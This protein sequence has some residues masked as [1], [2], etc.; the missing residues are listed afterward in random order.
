MIE[1][2]GKNDIV[3]V[4]EKLSNRNYSPQHLEIGVDFLIMSKCLGEKMSEWGTHTNRD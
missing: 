2:V 3:V 4:T 1:N